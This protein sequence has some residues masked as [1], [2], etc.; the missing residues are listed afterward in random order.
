MRH[1]CQSSKNATAQGTALAS[2]QSVQIIALVSAMRSA[3]NVYVDE[4]QEKAYQMSCANKEWTQTMRCHACVV[5]NQLCTRVNT[6]QCFQEAN[7][8]LPHK[9]AEFGLQLTSGSTTSR[10][11]VCSQPLQARLYTDSHCRV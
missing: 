7:R 9:V 3:A 5:E 11:K 4:M 6:I 1:Q 8:Q 10:N 2:L